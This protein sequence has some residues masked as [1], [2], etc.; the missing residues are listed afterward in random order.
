[1]VQ[2]TDAA[3]IRFS[4]EDGGTA[5]VL[6]AANSNNF[7]FNYGSS[8]VSYINDQNGSYNQSSDLR[9]KDDVKSLESVLPKLIKLNP[10]SYYFKND[11]KRTKRSIGLVAQDVASL[12]PELVSLDD[13][14]YY[15]ISYAEFGVLA[16]Q[17]IKELKEVV[18]QQQ[19]Q[20]EDLK[21]ANQELERRLAVIEAML[22]K[23][24]THP[25]SASSKA[26]K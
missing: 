23:S 13:R 6:G 26:E 3:G 1:L 9:L 2:T 25:T 18:Q 14:G 20:I 15:S 21:S 12:F 17:G 4:P 16:I 19:T 24:N 11:S 7:W 8:N 5:W 22:T 10:S